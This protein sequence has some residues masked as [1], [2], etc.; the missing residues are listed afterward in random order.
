MRAEISSYSSPDPPSTLTVAPGTWQAWGPKEGTEWECDMWQMNERRCCLVSGRQES[1]SKREG[2]AGC[3]QADLSFPRG[4]WA[5]LTLDQGPGGRFRGARRWDSSGLALGWWEEKILPP[6]PGHK[7]SSQ[8]RPLQPGP[9]HSWPHATGTWAV[10]PLSPDP[11][12]N[13]R[14]WAGH[15]LVLRANYSGSDTGTDRLLNLS[16]HQVLG[17]V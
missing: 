6:S 4:P 17:D 8:R 9:P 12:L 14:P 3:E 10:A 5:G 13:F 7:S 2:A 1:G 16:G 11:R 15:P